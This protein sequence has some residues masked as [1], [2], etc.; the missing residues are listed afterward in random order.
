MLVIDPDGIWR[1]PHQLG[2]LRAGLPQQQTAAQ[3]PPEQRKPV[4]G[5]YD[6]QMI[7]AKG[8]FG[9]VQGH[10][11]RALVVD[12]NTGALFVGVGSAGNLRVEPQP[13][14]HREAG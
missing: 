13:K 11:N 2:A 1:V 6:A 12:P 7:T 8:V 9:I 4:P 10:Q 14:G 3:V 5:A